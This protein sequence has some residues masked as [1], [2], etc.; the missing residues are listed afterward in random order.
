M[1]KS[2]I[3]LFRE[4]KLAPITFRGQTVHLSYKRQV[5]RSYLG[6]RFLKASS[7]RRQALVIALDKGV[8]FFDDQSSSQMVLWQNKAP[9]YL[10]L[11]C[12]PSQTETTI[13]IWNGWDNG[14]LMYGEGNTGMIVEVAGQKVE[15]R[16]SDGLDE[17]NFDDLM[18]EVYFL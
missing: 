16:C 1:E 17:P 8:L 4:S 12:E 6:V 5:T 18:A 9:S 2:L 13:T 10:E 15:L 14:S 3:Q 11:R 7:V